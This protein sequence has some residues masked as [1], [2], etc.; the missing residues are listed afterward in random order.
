M[1]GVRDGL[2]GLKKCVCEGSQRWLERIEEVCVCVRGVRDGLRGLKKCVCEGSQR[3][4]E[5]VEEVCV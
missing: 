5:R 4:L 3:W 2:R 1:R